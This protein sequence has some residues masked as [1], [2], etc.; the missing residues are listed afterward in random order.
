VAI[1]TL[2]MNSWNGTA[3]S[4]DSLSA[5]RLS[6]AIAS[7]FAEI[8]KRRAAGAYEQRSLEVKESELV[9]WKE[10]AEDHPNSAVEAMRKAAD[11]QDKLGQ[12]EVNIPAREMLGDLFMLEHKPEEALVEYRTA[13]KLSPNRLNGLLSAGHAAEQAKQT[14]E[15]MNYYKAAVQQ[16]DSGKH[17]QREDLACAVKATLVATR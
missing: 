16:T 10:Y 3:P 6:Y 2:L 11:Q 1:D 13:L 8:K 7:I 17:S 4:P 15:A 5:E 9:A 14:D 12:Q